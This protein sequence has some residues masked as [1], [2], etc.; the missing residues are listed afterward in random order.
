[1][2]SIHKWKLEE[3][4]GFF[5]YKV[6]EI[7]EAVATRTIKLQNINSGT[8]DICFDDSELVSNINFSFM[9]TE[10]IYDCKIL[11]L[12][13][14][15]RNPTINSI[16][17]QIL[18]KEIIIGIKKFVKVQVNKDIYYV[19]KKQLAEY[20]VNDSFMFD[21]TR[22]DLLQVEAIVHYFLTID[23]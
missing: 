18:D 3:Q 13:E 23:I 17:C 6:I 11:L 15:T 2:L 22:K 1:M 20:L 21:Y 5:A 8:I 12:G 4:G 19:S 9:K 10:Q 16:C 14:P 7:N